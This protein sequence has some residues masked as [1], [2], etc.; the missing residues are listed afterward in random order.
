MAQG[1]SVLWAYILGLHEA[2]LTV[3]QVGGAGRRPARRAAL[4]PLIGS[5]LTRPRS[6]GLPF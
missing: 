2:P 5:C 6:L 1:I 3:L 4:G